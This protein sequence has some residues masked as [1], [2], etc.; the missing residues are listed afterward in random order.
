MFKSICA[1]AFCAAALV[2]GSAHAAV[3][4]ATS[5]PDTS[6][7]INF[8]FVN[9]GGPDILS[10]SLDGSTG[11]NPVFW[12]GLGSPGGT[13]TL[14]STSGEDTTL[15]V[16]NFVAGSF[17][18]G[19]SFTLTG[20]DPDFVIGSPSVPISGLLG[21]S[22]SAVYSNATSFFG[23]FVDNPDEGAGLILVGDMSKVPVP[24]ALPLMLAGIGMLGMARRKQRKA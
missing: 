7:S 4:G 2:A 21:V 14:A 12:D 24:A 20:V 23:T 15:A 18:D 5:G 8:A 16:F 3:L 19:D 17:A 9:D 1:A 22:V 10:L 11:L 6:F 13:A